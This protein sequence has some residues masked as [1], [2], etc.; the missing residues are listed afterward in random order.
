M[1]DLFDSDF[2]QAQQNCMRL[3]NQMENIQAA[4][5][6]ENATSPQAQLYLLKTSYNKV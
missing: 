5:S 4:K 3:Q 6:N 2:K 1:T